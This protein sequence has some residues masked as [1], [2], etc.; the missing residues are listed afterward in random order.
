M[1]QKV[2]ATA[3]TFYWLYIDGKDVLPEPWIFDGIRRE[4]GK[5]GVKLD[6]W[7]ARAVNLEDRVLA[8]HTSIT[9]IPDY[10][11][12]GDVRAALVQTY[13]E[14]PGEAIEKLID[15]FYPPRE[16]V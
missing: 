12:T 10:I 7:L 2:N 1:T 6:R 14:T 3:P 9:S 11:A 15:H 16:N 5:G 8:D 13:G 4:Y